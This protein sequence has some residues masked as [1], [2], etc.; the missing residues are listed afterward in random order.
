MITLYLATLVP[1]ALL[2]AVMLST[3]MKPLFRSALGPQL[4]ESPR[5]APAIAFY[6]G[7]TALL[8]LLA[9]APAL[10]SGSPSQALVTGALLGLMAYGTYELTSI[11]VLKDWTW[12]MTVTDLVW[13]TVLTGLS[14][15]IGVL[16]SRA[17][18]G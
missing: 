4:L 5:W 9:G 6:L 1:F 11:A 18:A 13:G 2:D 14:A 17:F 12:R 3:V 16:V 8:T 15:W 10:K 7:Y